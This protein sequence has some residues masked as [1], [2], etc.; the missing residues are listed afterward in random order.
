MP[1]TRKKS[2]HGFKSQSSPNY[3]FGSK[4]PVSR[5][6][7]K[8]AP[9]S[10]NSFRGFGSTGSYPGFGDASLHFTPQEANILER[11]VNNLNEKFVALDR[12]LNEKIKNLSD[13][14]DNLEGKK[15]KKS[16]SKKSTSSKSKK[17]STS[18]KSR[19]AST[20]IKSKIGQNSK[21]NLTQ[22]RQRLFAEIKNPPKKSKKKNLPTQKSF[23][24]RKTG[25]MSIQNSLQDA[26]STVL[27][28]RR[29]GVTGNED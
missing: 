27:Q 2:G 10:T 1:S 14:I 29:K 25:R 12:N 19:R 5:L 15:T 20:T 3:G 13:R 17:T 4:A 7:S 24:E 22:A 21:N 28:T 6:S 8:S 26:L 23:K 16:L 18:S 11:E 9:G